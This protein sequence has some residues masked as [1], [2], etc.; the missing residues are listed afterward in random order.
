LAPGDGFYLFTAPFG[1]RRGRIDF[2][3]GVREMA[4]LILGLIG[5]E[6]LV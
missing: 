6:I 1:R 3:F 4:W 5:N 2:I